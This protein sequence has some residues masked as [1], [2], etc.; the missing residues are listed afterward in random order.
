M[1]SQRTILD[2]IDLAYGATE[3]D[4]RWPIFLDQFA[5]TLQAQIGTLYIHDAKSQKAVTDIAT[6]M[7]P[8][9]RAAYRAHYA[10][11]NVYLTNKGALVAGNVATSEELCPDGTVLRSEFYN[12]WIRPQSLRRGLNGVL[13]NQGS[14]IGNI[15]AIRARSGRPFSVEDNAS[16]KL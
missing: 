13:F 1:H 2:L 10:S 8:T 12:D 11:K 7:D 16:S 5:H 4:A 9:Y 6:G 14:L 3:D 15:G